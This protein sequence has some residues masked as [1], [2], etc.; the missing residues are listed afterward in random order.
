MVADWW[1]GMSV[2]AMNL[3]TICALVAKIHPHRI[4]RPGVLLLAQA[5]MR[6]AQFHELGVLTAVVTQSM[7]CEAVMSRVALQGL[8]L[9][10]LCG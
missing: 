1:R 3:A 2:P 9:T 6:L 10:S 4:G 8:M 7:I 5:M